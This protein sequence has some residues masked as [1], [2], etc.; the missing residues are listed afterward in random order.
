MSAFSI[1]LRVTKWYNCVKIGRVSPE[2]YTRRK[3]D[4]KVKRIIALVLAVIM[5]SAVAVACSGGGE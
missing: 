1:D 4:M 3:S 5:V 2:K